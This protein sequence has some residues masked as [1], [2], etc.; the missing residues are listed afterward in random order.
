MPTVFL[1][2]VMDGSRELCSQELTF[3]DGDMIRIPEPGDVMLVSDGQNTFRGRVSGKDFD[4]T[5]LQAGNEA[6]GAL[7][8]TVWSD[9]I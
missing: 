4:Y 5:Q 9:V 7:V 2:K 1:L 3:D 8:V 6:N